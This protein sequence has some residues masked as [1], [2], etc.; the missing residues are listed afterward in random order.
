MRPI[1]TF[2]ICLGPIAIPIVDEGFQ[3]V[4][5]P[6][7][8]SVRGVGTKLQ[9]ADITFFQVVDREGT[10]V[11]SA[12]AHM[13]IYCKAE[14]D[15]PAATLTLIPTPISPPTKRRRS[16]PKPETKPDEPAG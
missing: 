2:S 7:V 9:V 15:A 13:V 12:P 8:L 4:S 3:L 16:K 14:D 1:K 10:A 11:F 6:Q 5:P